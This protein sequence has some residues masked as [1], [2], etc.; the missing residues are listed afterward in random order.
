M[1]RKTV[2]TLLS[3]VIIGSIF[4]NV[5]AHGYGCSYSS[6]Q[7]DPIVSTEW[8][9]Q[10]INDN[11]MILLDVRSLEKYNE[12][13]IA[14]SVSGPVAQWWVVRNDLLLELPESDDLLTLIG[15][16]GITARTKVVIIGQT[17]S[18]YDRADGSR[19]AWTLIY[20]GIKNVALL[21]GG[22]TKWISE[23]RTT[24]TE[25]YL[26]TPQVYAGHF[27]KQVSIDKQF[28]YY[29]LHSAKIIDARIPDDFFGVSPLMYSEKEGH[30]KGAS[31]L[32]T[33]WIFTETGT[34]KDEA[35]LGKMAAGVVGNCKQ[36][37]VITYCGVGGYAATWWFVLSEVLGYQNVKLYDGSIQEWTR[38]P[39]APVEKFSW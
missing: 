25:P 21:D 26:P 6:R 11:N 5:C 38:D 14:G 3:V 12:G 7:I 31:S 37:R 18:D 10:N 34:F 1:L 39:K 32:P 28:V 16:A 36:L 4:N 30:I 35:T 13:H 2:V 33:P 15:N 20:A 29:S 22:I 23:K 8:L 24:T 19:V 9:E 27:N 17:D